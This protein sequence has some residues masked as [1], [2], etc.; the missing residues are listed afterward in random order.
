MNEQ[1]L[2]KNPQ[3]TMYPEQESP[4]LVAKEP[5]AL[6]E[7]QVDMSFE[8]EFNRALATSITGDELRRRMYERIEA[9]PWKEKSH[10]QKK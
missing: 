7:T 2:S 10:I 8:E 5:E 6:C 3:G 1:D 4:I 9:W